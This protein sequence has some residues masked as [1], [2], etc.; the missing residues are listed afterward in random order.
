MVALVDVPKVTFMRVF[1]YFLCIF[2]LNIFFYLSTFCAYVEGVHSQKRFATPCTV[3]AIQ[4]L[5]DADE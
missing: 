2:N 4:H 5:M 1:I 3:I